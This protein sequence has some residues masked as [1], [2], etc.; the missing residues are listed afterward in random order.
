M[1]RIILFLIAFITV[2]S[3][4]ID[5]PV[6]NRQALTETYA[7]EICYDT[8]ELSTN[9]LYELFLH[10]DFGNMTKAAPYI[11][12]LEQF[13]EWLEQ[14]AD[15]LIVTFTAEWCGPCKMWMPIFD[16]VA[17]S[18]EDATD[19]KCLFGKVDVDEAEDIAVE[20]EIRLLPTTVLIKNNYI[21]MSF[22]GAGMTAIELI[23]H[24]D[25]Y[26]KMNIS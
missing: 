15:L 25:K 1:K 26:A 3:C 6:T 7:T 24:I 8:I 21:V 17:E 9:Q 12:D 22:T 14:S 2:Y 23:G 11:K 4:Q 5:R 16:Q 18:Y 20:L 19:V 10:T 13:E